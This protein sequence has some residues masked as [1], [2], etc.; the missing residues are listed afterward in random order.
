MAASSLIVGDPST[1]VVA[2]LLDERPRIHAP[3]RGQG[4]HDVEVS[5]K[6]DRRPPRVGATETGDQVHLS[7]VGSHDLD[8]LRPKSG[9]E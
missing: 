9:I 1:V 3:V 2:V 4:F 6:K 8:V 7:L 5:Q